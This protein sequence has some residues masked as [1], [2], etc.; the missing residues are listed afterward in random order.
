MGHGMIR[1]LFSGQRWYNMLEG[2]DGLIRAQNTRGNMSSLHSKVEAIIWA[3]ECMG[4]Y[5]SFKS[6]LQRIVLNW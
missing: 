6:F 1:N 2:F 4:I 3:T 5:V